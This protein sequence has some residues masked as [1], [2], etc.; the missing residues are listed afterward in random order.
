M[1]ERFER[2]GPVQDVSRVSSGSPAVI[3]LT[4][5][6]RHEPVQVVTAALVLAARGLSLLKAKRVLEEM[7]AKGRAVVE[8]PTVEDPGQLAVDLAEAGCAAASVTRDAVDVRAVR[9]R[10]GLTQ[11]QFAWRYGLD[12]AAIR[13]WETGRRKPD[14]AA[15]G[16][17]RV[18]D[19]LP[20]QVS[21]VLEKPLGAS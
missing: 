1:K 2:L 14:P 10:L 3:S 20:D 11:E 18:I 9:E 5:A 21:R 8:L 15:S 13:N 4:T 6:S 17:L 16:Y 19:H 12:V 7:L